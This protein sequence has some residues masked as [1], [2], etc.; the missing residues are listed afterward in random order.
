MMN[1]FQDWNFHL[2]ENTHLAPY[3]TLLDEGPSE[4]HIVT[5]QHCFSTGGPLAST[6]SYTSTG[7]LTPGQPSDLY[8]TT[9]KLLVKL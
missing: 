1:L 6:S 9:G 7:T 8:S 3:A 4:E 2:G 5:S